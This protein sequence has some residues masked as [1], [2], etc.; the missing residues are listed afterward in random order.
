M[1]SRFPIILAS[2]SP[3]R[4]ELLKAAGFIFTVRTKQ[5][6]EDYPDQVRPET[7]AE[8]LALK[9]AKAFDEEFHNEVVITADTTVVINNSVLGKASN[10][11]EAFEMIKLLSGKTHSVITGV[12]LRSSDKLV[13]FS[14]KTEITFK[15][16]LDDEI[17]Y[18]IENYKPFDKAG[19][20]GI[21]EWIGLIGVVEIK[22]DF[23]NVMGLPVARVYRQLSEW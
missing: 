17:N 5:V 23:Y 9:K 7:V 8:Y 6:E 1:N 12:C 19:A 16:F 10:H 11:E 13:S 20:Y 3:R 4:Q 14:E 15:E 2:K 21:Q 18:Y 22:G